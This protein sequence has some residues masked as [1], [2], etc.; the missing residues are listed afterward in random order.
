MLRPSGRHLGV[1]WLISEWHACLRPVDPGSRTRPAAAPAHAR[2]T[3]LAGP[4]GDSHHLA[5]GETLVEQYE[6]GEGRGGLGLI[7]TE[8][9]A[10]M[11]PSASISTSRESPRTGSPR[12]APQRGLGL[13]RSP[14]PSATPKGT[15]VTAAQMPLCEPSPPPRNTPDP[16]ARRDVRRQARR[17]KCERHP[18]GRPDRVPK[19]DSRTMPEPASPPTRGRS[20]AAS[21]RS[22]TL[23]GP[24]NSKVTAIPRGIRS[25]ARRARLIATRTGRTRRQ[26]PAGLESPLTAGRQMA[27]RIRAANS[28]LRKTILPGPTSSKRDFASAPPSWTDATPANTS[29]VGGIRSARIMAGDRTATRELT[30]EELAGS[31]AT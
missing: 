26:P 8:H 3:A 29:T 7:S 15:S 6:A 10:G 13:S 20:T 30:Y 18:G 1:T 9:P 25:I 23:S 27:T 2:R 28:T 11:P 21:R 19:S 16:T 14:P 5:G 31:S 24:T 4:L 22:P 17:Q 12:R